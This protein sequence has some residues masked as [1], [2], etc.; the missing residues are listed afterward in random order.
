MFSLE[1]LEK[2]TSE[3]FLAHGVPFSLKFDEDLGN[4]VFA[5]TGQWVT[6]DADK[7]EAIKKALKRSGY[8]Q[9]VAA[10]LS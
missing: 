3:V 4:W 7:A 6:V 10:K 2:A 1:Q 5:V 9:E 8:L